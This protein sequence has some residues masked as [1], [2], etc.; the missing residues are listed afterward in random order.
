MPK[1]LQLSAKHEMRKYFLDLLI[2]GNRYSY[3][4]NRSLL[5]QLKCMRGCDKVCVSP[6]GSGKGGQ[7]QLGKGK[8]KG[9]ANGKGKG[10]GN[11]RNRMPTPAPNLL[12]NM[13][14]SRRLPTGG[15]R[16]SQQQLLRNPMLQRSVGFGLNSK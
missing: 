11:K 13:L 14:N 3:N 8:G 6:G 7:N 10:K 1:R 16:G 9:K 5:S 12:G 4:T 2:P 15:I